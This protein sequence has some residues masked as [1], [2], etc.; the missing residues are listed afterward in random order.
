MKPSLFIHGWAQ[1][2]Q[3]WF[4][5]FE[6][7]AATRFLNLP[8]HGGAADIPADRWLDS[9][10]AQLPEEP[11]HLV[12]WSLGGMLA[13]QVAAAFPERVASLALVA[14]T[15]R[16][17]AADGW[18]HGSSE[19]IFEGF[20]D[21]VASGS[22]KAL[23]RFFMLMLH[24]DDLSRSDYN[25]LARESVDREN[26]PGAA[27]LAGGLELLERLDLRTLAEEVSSPTLI[28]HG[29]GDAIVP[30]AAGIWLAD[31]IT[32]AEQH[33]FRACGHA[34]FLTQPEEFNTTLQ[35]WWQQL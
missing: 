20:R 14:T 5:Q 2:R 34:P 4:N 33:I 32:G 13:M 11:V 16:F 23:N 30:V 31:T 8:G 7:F 6:T 15:P 1:S 22:P 35:R 25:A 3:I 27:G 17:R 12:G 10:V 19:E 29:E 18:P 28:L 21:A 26:R 24:G 9:I